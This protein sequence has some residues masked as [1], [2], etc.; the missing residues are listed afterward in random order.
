MGR[1]EK[2]YRNLQQQAYDKLTKMLHNGEGT[3]KKA[4]MEDGTAKDKI[5]SYNT[6]KTYKQ[7][8]YAFTRYIEKEHPECRNLKQARPYVREYLQKS[9]DEGKSAWTVQTQ[10]KAL[11]KLYGITPDSKDYFEPPVRHREDITRSR[12]EAVRDRHFSEKNNDEL[13]R[14][15]KG[16]GAR[17][18]GMTKMTGK[19]L[20]TREQID[21]HVSRLEKTASERE[22][23]EKER[24]Q[25][26][27]CKDAQRF[28]GCTHYVY[29]KE[30]GGRERI[31]PIVGPDKDRIVERFQNTGRD[32]K[33]WQHVSTNADI[34]GY[35]GEYATRIYRMYARDIDELRAT[36]AT[37]NY[38]GKE[39]SALYICRKDERGKVLDKQAMEMASKA[40]GHNRLEVVA[41]NYIRGL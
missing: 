28:N 23:T 30:K 2:Y 4:A 5:F 7:Q 34:H 14:F 22:L 25:L 32:E 26:N 41:N 39:V 36:H 31:S 10:A 6:Y 35:R 18:E 21:K 9:V 13:V 33:V 40:L 27:I 11:G 12:G 24:T 1:S 15:C 38:Q 37:F 16:V 8:S 20:M 17:R 19:D 3:S 29:L